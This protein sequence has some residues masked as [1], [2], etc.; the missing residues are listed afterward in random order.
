[1][2]ERIRFYQTSSSIQVHFQGI[3]PQKFFLFIPLDPWCTYKNFTNFWCPSHLGFMEVRAHSSFWNSSLF[4]RGLA[5]F[6]NII[7]KN[8]MANLLHLKYLIERF[9][10]K[11]FV[12]IFLINFYFLEGLKPI[13]A[14]LKIIF[15]LFKIN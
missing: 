4:N 3:H 6:F 13:P 12:N 5:N 14:L 9:S 15:W 2:W 8:F 1:M 11:V 10:N 7:F